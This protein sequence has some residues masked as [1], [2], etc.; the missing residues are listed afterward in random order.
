MSYWHIFG[1]N[2]EDFRNNVKKSRNL[3]C[4]SFEHILYTS[5]IIDD[6]FLKL[7]KISFDELYMSTKKKFLEENRKPRYGW[8]WFHQF[9][10]SYSTEC[11]FQTIFQ[12]FPTFWW[13]IFFVP[14]PHN[15]C[16]IS[17]FGQFWKKYHIAK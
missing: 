1:I 5:D 7:F 15:F 9:G 12:L 8:N 4:F 10:R 3:G 16:W 14:L 17:R 11:E 2:P 13:K 6:C